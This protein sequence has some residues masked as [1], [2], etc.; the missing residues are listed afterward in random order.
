MKDEKGVE[1]PIYPTSLPPR[2]NPFGEWRPLFYAGDLDA[3]DKKVREM[4]GAEKDLRVRGCLKYMLATG[5]PTIEF[6][7]VSNFAFPHPDSGTNHEFGHLHMRKVDVVN[8]E[9][10]T[11]ANVQVYDCSVEIPEVT[12]EAIKNGLDLITVL[13]YRLAYGLN[14]QYEWVLKY[15]GV[16]KGGS[17]VIELTDEDMDLAIS[18]VTKFRGKD[19]QVFDRAISWYQAGTRLASQN[20]LLSFLSYYLALEMLALELRAG[21]M[22]TS[23]DYGFAELSEEQESKEVNQCILAL[24]NT[25]LFETDPKKF[26]R[27]AYEDCILGNYRRTKEALIAV[28]GTESQEVKKFRQRVKKDGEEYSLY[29]VRSNIAHGTFTPIEEDELEVIDELPDVAELARKF[30]SKLLWKTEPTDIER[31]FSISMMMADPRSSGITNDVNMIRRHDWKI[32]L[33]WLS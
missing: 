3:L 12:V 5:Y 10:N 19:G 22:E 27:K 20:K 8:V 26:V 1:H 23:Q 16:S 7:V 15:P 9:N 31:R 24:K 6:V 11:A 17:S 33:E 29:K 21:K 32:K 4:F 13:L 30:I 25:G 2:Y 14:A 28:F 18:Y